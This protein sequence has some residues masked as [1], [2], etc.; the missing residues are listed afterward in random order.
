MHTYRLNADVTVFNDQLEVPRI[1]FLP[2]T[3]RA[4]RREPV[5]IDTGLLGLPDR[6]FVQAL[7]AVSTL[8]TSAGS[9]SPIPTGS[10]GRLFQTP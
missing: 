2:A 10:H 7:R 4:P 1:G 9:G 5:V 6:D 3:L 8:R